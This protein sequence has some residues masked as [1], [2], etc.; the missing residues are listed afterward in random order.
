VRWYRAVDR[1]V[2]AFLAAA[3]GIEPGSRVVPLLFER[4]AS[5]GVLGYL[6]HAISYP[7]AEKGFVDW[8][9]Y[10]AQTALFPVRFRRGL[11]RPDTGPLEIAPW[12]MDVRTRRDLIDFVYCWKVPQGAPLNHHLRRFYTL[13]AEEGPARLYESKDRIRERKTAA[14]AM[15]K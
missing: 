15:R 5:L 7:A 8:G 10:E 6:G 14:R 13:V 1:E 2:D 11:E 12:Y 4:K 3:P 9:N